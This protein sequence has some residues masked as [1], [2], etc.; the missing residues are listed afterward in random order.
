M[1]LVPVPTSVSRVS[2]THEGLEIE[3]PAKRN[4]F[5]VAF[6]SFWLC[7]WAFGEVSVSRQLL[8]SKFSE[9][10]DLFLIAWL[11]MWT[12]GG[13]FA[14]YAWT[15]MLLGK[16]RIVLGS[17]TLAIV[18]DVAGYKR[19]KEY[20]LAHISNLHVAA[21]RMSM[22]DPSASMQF[23]GISGGLITFD[24]GSKTFR[25]GASLDEAEARTLCQQMVR[26][27]P[28]LGLASAA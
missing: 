10:P 4:L 19:R 1:A 23:W 6:L 5:L 9:S 26:R 13:A 20:D 2:E 24:Y 27:R 8:D 11:G 18:R 7:G 16:E 28:T 25:V 22:F 12:I 15:W 14:V 21:D 17:A 3:I